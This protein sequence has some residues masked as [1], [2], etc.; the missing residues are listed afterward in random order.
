MAH[1]QESSHTPEDS[2][3]DHP[4]EDATPD[5][6]LGKVV[7]YGVGL[8]G[9]SLGLALLD[10]G[11]SEEVVGI[12][13]SAAPLEEAK[14][15]GAVT[16]FVTLPGADADES[17]QDEAL[18]A[19]LAGADL[20]VLC[21]PVEHIRESLPRVCRH[22]P[23]GCIIT[24]V[25]STKAHIVA[26]GESAAASRKSEISFVGSHPMAG[27]DR[28]GVIHARADL[29][30]NATVYLTPTPNSNWTAVAK[31][32]L[33]WTSLGSRMIL[34]R[35]ERH[36]EL[37]A[38]TSHLPFMAST[39]VVHAMAGSDEDRNLLKALVAGGFRDTTRIA[40]GHPDMWC[41]ILRENE[42]QIRARIIA[43]REALNDIEAALD[44]DSETPGETRSLLAETSQFRA[45][46]EE[47]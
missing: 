22:A 40:K 16:H 38:L 30:Q 39:A 35:P 4:Y 45:W 15:L 10:R 6:T 44:H 20:I 34:C 9:G 46:F 24:D 21:T 47:A 27:S 31:L 25:G 5:L 26:S 12:G 3:S 14:R 17:L 41:D 43:L 37:A 42:T 11:V 28:S 2:F 18:A 7:I 33:F 19:G 8:L 36:D 13:R 23:A 32:S 29:F 1:S